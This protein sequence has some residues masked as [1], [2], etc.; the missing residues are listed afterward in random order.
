ME[1]T[2]K[3]SYFRLHNDEL[4]AYARVLEQGISYKD[5]A[6]IGR[7]VTSPLFE[8]KTMGMS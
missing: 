6:S 8:E 3:Y 5:Y 2:L 7:I 4:V 1:K